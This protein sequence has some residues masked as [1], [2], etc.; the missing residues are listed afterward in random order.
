MSVQGDAEYAPIS[1]KFAQ[2]EAR[3][4]HLYTFAINLWVLKGWPINK[5]GLLLPVTSSCT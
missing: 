1:P 3:E 4:R 2:L 5:P